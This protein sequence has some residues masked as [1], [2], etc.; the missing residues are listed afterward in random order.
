VTVFAGLVVLGC[1]PETFVGVSAAPSPRGVTGSVARVA[2]DAA[3]SVVAIETDVGQGMGF[4]IDE[5]GYVVTSRHV[6]E[7]VGHVNDV[8]WPGLAGEHH[9]RS[10]QIVYIDPTHDLALLKVEAPGE[11]F[12]PIPLTAAE[13]GRTPVNVVGEPV[14]LTT[15]LDEPTLT[16][17][18]ERG[19]VT[20]AEV[21]NKAVGPGPYIGVTN[22]I[23]RGQ[24]GGPVLDL[25]GRAV[26]VVT[27]MWKDKPGGFA[28]PASRVVEMLRSR[29]SLSTL[30]EHRARVRT[31]VEG[32]SAALRTGH[33]TSDPRRFIAPSSARQVRQRTVD[34]LLDRISPEGMDNF[35]Q[36]L[37]QLALGASMDPEIAL[38]R[39]FGLISRALTDDTIASMG[40]KG[41]LP[42]GQV[43]TFFLELGK[44]YLSARIYG[45]HGRESALE[46]ARRRLHT[47]DSA[48][49]FLMADFVD[50]TDG[51]DG[52]IDEITVSPGAY[53]P[54]AVVKMSP[55]RRLGRVSESS[56][57]VQLALEWGDWYVVDVH[58]QETNA[59]G[60][61]AAVENSTST[62][63]VE[64]SQA[65][66]W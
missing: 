15:R 52:E 64:P 49:I 62:W 41:A 55:Q 61:V 23:Q 4:V 2:K 38:E 50:A 46:I 54:R 35:A 26:G 12:K 45:A 57:Y 17:G 25:R 6:V 7:Q 21:M 31:R 16:L 13:D 42:R 28:V 8:R 36:M 48:R 18:A 32:F 63:R 60:R 56:V 1:S 37:D 53:G 9:A 14:V 47:L 30:G 33:D 27:W 20:D 10:V 65:A 51:L 11:H 3:R 29:P 34:M 39:L 40:L 22:S 44:A 19:E 43:V 24:S 59:R 58:H 5:A 66:H